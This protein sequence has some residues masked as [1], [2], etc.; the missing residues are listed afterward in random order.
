MTLS[1]PGCLRARALFELFRYDVVTA[2]FGFRGVRRGLRRRAAGKTAARGSEREIS[3]A[4]DWAM[5]VYWKR[6]RCLQRST[7]AA[8]LLRAYGL[9]ADLVIGCRMTPFYGH[10]WVELSGRI[11]NG[12]GP[13]PDRL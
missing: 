5:T 13:F 12:P 8:R 4:I 9:P 10:A 11:L 2:L 3:Q 6:V 7:A 1:Y